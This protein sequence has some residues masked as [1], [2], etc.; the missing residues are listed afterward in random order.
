MSGQV[1]P[2]MLRTVIA[3]YVL[4]EESHTA[5]FQDGAAL[6]PKTQNSPSAGAAAL[7]LPIAAAWAAAAVTIIFSVKWFQEFNLCL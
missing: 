7:G 6:L 2:K 5:R 1:T 4:E 3:A